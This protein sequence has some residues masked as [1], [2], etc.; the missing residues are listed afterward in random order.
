MKVQ[1]HRL[2]PGDGLKINPTGMDQ[3]FQNVSDSIRFF[4]RT[5]KLL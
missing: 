5:I 3:R 1:V 2:P 4:Q